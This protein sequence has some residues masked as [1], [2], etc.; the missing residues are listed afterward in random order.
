MRLTILLAIAL[1]CLGFVL[2]GVLGG[3]HFAW[4]RAIIQSAT[5]FRQ[6]RPELTGATVWFTQ[7]GGSMFLLP[8]TAI[9]ALLTWFRG[10]RVETA[11]L[12]GSTLSGRLV[13]ELLKWW[14]DRPRPSFDA[15]PV[16]VLS[17]AFPSGH[18]GNSMLTYV[19]IALFAVPPQWRREALGAAIVLSLL[20][21]AT[22][23]LLGVHWPTD[24]IGGWLFGLVWMIAAWR[25]ASRRVTSS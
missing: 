13:I 19:A 14:T 6:P 12:L 8:L 10:R 16:T 17:Q 25:L 1:C 21:G 22:R 23:P 15:H 18:A 3:P 5:L 4:D 2:A 7:L 11:W 9:V 24:V 20:V